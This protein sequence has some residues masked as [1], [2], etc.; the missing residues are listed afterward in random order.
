MEKLLKL[1][2]EIEGIEVTYNYDETYSNLYNAVIDYMNDTQEWDFEYLFEDFVTYDVAEDIARN[3][4][5]NGGLVRLY[6]FLGNANLNNDLF[7]V[8]GYGNLEDISKED[9]D[10]LKDEILGSIE[11]KIND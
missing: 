6:Y 1:R 9:L 4:L 10:Y 5:D 2:K 3:E 8:N 7:R 11:E